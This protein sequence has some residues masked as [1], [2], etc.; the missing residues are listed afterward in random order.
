MSRDIVAGIDNNYDLD[1]P[2]TEIRYGL[3]FPHQFRPVLEHNKPL[4]QKVTG[5]FSRGKAAGALS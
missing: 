3:D 5:F 1:C 2:G 4:V